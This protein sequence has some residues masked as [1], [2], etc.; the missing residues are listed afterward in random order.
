MGNQTSGSSQDIS[1]RCPVDAGFQDHYD[2][3][4]GPPRLGGPYFGQMRTYLLNT[5]LSFVEKSGVRD[6][7]V[8]KIYVDLPHI[9]F[10]A[11][12]PDLV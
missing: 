8:V 7:E 11:D 9:G 1:P 3:I 2:R 5:F 10:R 12:R 4:A 6:A